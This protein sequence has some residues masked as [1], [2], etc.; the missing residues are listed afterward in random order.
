MTSPSPDI[1]PAATPEADWAEQQ[2]SVD[3]ADDAELVGPSPRAAVDRA[4]ADEAD[5][6]EQEIPAYLEDDEV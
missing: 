3:P 2:Q 4:E 5:L 6:V 1:P